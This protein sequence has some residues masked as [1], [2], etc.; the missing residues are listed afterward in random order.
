ML[1]G[2]LSKVCFLSIFVGARNRYT[3]HDLVTLPQEIY[4]NL[5]AK[6]KRILKYPSAIHSHPLY[7][8]FTWGLFSNICFVNSDPLINVH[9]WPK[10][11]RNTH[12]HHDTNHQRQSE[13]GP[14]Y[15]V[16]GPSTDELGVELYSHTHLHPC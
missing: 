9:Q 16:S 1:K 4:Q 13:G 14:Y 5:R 8:H 3:S 15:N 2:G 10:T 11:N 6:P 7:T 12:T